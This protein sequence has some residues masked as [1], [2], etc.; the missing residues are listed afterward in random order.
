MY[1]SLEMDE[2]FPVFS[3]IVVDTGI[4]VQTLTWYDSHIWF[5]CHSNNKHWTMKIPN[6]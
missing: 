2:N 6:V 3:H 1:E 4:G 5:R